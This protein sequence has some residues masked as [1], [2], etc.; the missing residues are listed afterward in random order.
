MRVIG[1]GQSGHDGAATN[2]LM[3]DMPSTDLDPRDIYAADG[4][5]LLARS[6]HLCR[7][8]TYARAL[9][10]ALQDGVV[11]PSGLLFKSLYETEPDTEASDDDRRLR[12]IITRRVRA[13]C[14]T[15]DAAGLLT[16]RQWEDSLVYGK[17]VHGE[18]I[19][20]RVWRPRPGASHATAWRCIHPARVSNPN[21]AGD[22]DRRHQGVEL[23]AHGAPLGLWIQSRHPNR[24]FAGTP[25][26]IYVPLRDARG[27]EQVIWH[28]ARTEPEQLRAPGFFA[29][30]MV[31]LTHLGKV[32][33]AHVVA[34]R[35]QA[36]IGMIVEADDPVAAARKDRNG[37][38]WT[39]ETVMSPGKTY[40]VKRGSNVRSFDF[41]YEGADYEAFTYALL[42][43]MCAAFGP[44]IP[45]DYVMHRL[46]KSSLASARAALAQA[47][48]SFRRE[49]VDHERELRIVVRN[50]L[51]ED[52]RLGRLGLPTGLDLDLACAGYFVTPPRLT[53]DD[54]REM[55]AAESKRRVLGISRTT[56]A[57][58]YG[59]Y[60]LDDEREQNLED[61]AL[62]AALGG[63]HLPPD[64]L[65]DD[66]DDDEEDED[67]RTPAEDAA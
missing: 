3:R 55:Q 36:C 57:R 34:K 61:L 38:A 18:A 31:L 4:A 59:G 47:W 67:D 2:R 14:N 7:N 33:D 17:A 13:A 43:S 23:D 62:Y 49:Q 40:Y 28:S 21:H 35:L 42:Q 29:P 53:T 41:K 39:R 45:V 20:V 65:D 15:V 54:H 24:L 6:S 19:K 50:A 12:R 8:N 26:W 16:F 9:I 51:D 27:L 22:T 66:Q 58:E 52:L 37:V 5:V 60:D 48:R 1:L 46:T 44:G 32:T 10:N 30:L 11:G 56:L 63:A 25:H 64:A